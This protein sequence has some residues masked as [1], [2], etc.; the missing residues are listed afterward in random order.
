[1]S[2]G[3]AGGGARVGVA[4][5]AAGSG[6][7]MGGVRKPFLSLRGEPVLL[8]A[9]R[10]FLADG[11]VVAVVVALGE[12]DAADPPAWLTA[13]DARVRVVA[14]GATRAESVRNALRA[15][16]DDLDVVAVHDAA[17]P[18]VTGDVVSRCIDVAVGGEGAV[19]GCPA[20]DTM[21]EVDGEGRVVATPDRAR[22]WHAHTPQV[23]PA[24]VARR[25]YGGE[26][27][28]A[29]DDAS[30]VEGMEIPVRMVDGGPLNLK[31]TRPED[32]L[33]ADAVLRSRG[34]GG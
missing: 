5:P 22:L 10:P 6:Q 11:R 26:L 1:M 9:L 4:I 21:K 12:A 30:L 33:V 24:A 34:G 16:P 18:L 28:S 29:T 19:A 3:G 31:V 23:F 7:R 32:V 14:G 27:G 13:V 25:A 8:H 15:L 17:R 2:P 20:V